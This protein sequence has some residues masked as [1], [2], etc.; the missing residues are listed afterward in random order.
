[1]SRSCPG[2]Q[3]CRDIEGGFHQGGEGRRETMTIRQGT[4]CILRFSK[5]ATQDDYGISMEGIE[6]RRKEEAR[7]S[8][9]PIGKKR[10]PGS[11]SHRPRAQ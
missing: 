8:D 3:I 11:G 1:M 4:S 9:V 10:P 6:G 7:C 2:E 5:K